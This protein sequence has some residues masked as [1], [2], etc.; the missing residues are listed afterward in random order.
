MTGPAEPHDGEPRDKDPSERDA[1]DEAA[2]DEDPYETV[3]HQLAVL[4]R[5]VRAV[6]RTAAREVHPDL[7]PTAYGLLIRLDETGGARLTDL[8]AHFGVGKP[9]L[10]RQISFLERLGLVS[11]VEEPDD[12]RSARLQLSE[13]GAT[14]LHAAR[15]SRRVELRAQLERWPEED[16]VTFGRLLRRLTDEAL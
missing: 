5:K 14:R 10:S 3:T 13:Q 8:A 15:R 6:S 12:R 9:S 11:R 7:D 4:L 2:Y 16:V 1:Y